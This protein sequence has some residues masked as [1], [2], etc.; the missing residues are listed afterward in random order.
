MTT[1]NVEALI[2]RMLGQIDI[3]TKV[4]GTLAATHS[5]GRAIQII[6]SLEQHVANAPAKSD[7]QRNHLD[8]MARALKGIREIL[9]T[10]QSAAEI[11]DL[12]PHSKN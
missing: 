8:G 2:A 12:A 9:E 5:D 7:H 6:A 4:V 11:S 3:L 1:S 10:A